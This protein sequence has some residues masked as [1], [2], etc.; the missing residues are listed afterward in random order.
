MTDPHS[1]SPVLTPC[2]LCERIGASPISAQPYERIWSALVVEYQA[3]FSQDVIQRLTPDAV[4]TLVECGSCGLQYFTPAVPG[5]E[6]FYS[7]LT[8]TA[9]SYYTEDKWDFQAALSWVDSSNVLLDI[10]CG[11]GAWMSRARTRAAEVVGIDTNPDAVSKARRIGLEVYRVSL[12]QFAADN[13][14]RFD[15]VSAFQVVEHI[16][17]VLPF[18]KAAADCLKPGGR[19]LV[20]VPNRLRSVRARFEPLDH[21]PHHLS[22]WSAPQFA[23]LGRAAGLTLRQVSFQPASMSECRA[24]LRSRIA[25]SGHTESLVARALGRIVFSPSLYALYRR[26]GLLGYWQLRGMSMMAVLEK[27]ANTGSP[28]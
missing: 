23:C 19:L 17:K 22:R 1:S 5:D 8:T 16:D 26:F 14:S 11:E 20:T 6:N 4:T 13:N 7:Q 9:A 15:V 2:P 3:T 10:A 27:S 28:P 12:E 21:P 24:S 18:I 25:P